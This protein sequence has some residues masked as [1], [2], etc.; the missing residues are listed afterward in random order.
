MVEPTQV[1]LLAAGLGS[2][3]GELGLGRPKALFEVDGRALVDRALD[4]AA[5]FAPTERIVVGGYRF[6]LVSAHLAGRGLRVVENPRF[7][8]GNHYTVAAALPAL[9]GAVLIMNIDHLYPAAMAERIRG[10]PGTHITAMCD[11]DRTLVADDMKVKL[12]DGRLTRIAKTLSEHDC[13]YIGMTYVPAAWLERYR[14][15]AADT[16]SEVGDSASAESVLGRLAADGEPIAIGDVSGI[17]WHEIDTPEDYQR[18][19]A[20]HV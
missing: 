7:R 9:T 8:A 13:G 6:D 16:S 20:R 18:Y 4:F 15:A 2:R 14:R 10:L 17:G 5:A 3:L 11:F 12:A 19:L 1:V